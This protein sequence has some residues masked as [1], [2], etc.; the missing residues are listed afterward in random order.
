MLQLLMLLSGTTSLTNIIV[1]IYSRFYIVEI[2]DI[3]N[4]MHTII[5]TR[6]GSLV[7]IH[8]QVETSFRWASA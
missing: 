1:M 6:V 4:V 8:V 2:M 5:Y 7:L 3:I